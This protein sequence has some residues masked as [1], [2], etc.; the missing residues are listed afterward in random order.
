LYGHV[1][2]DEVGTHLSWLLNF[3]G[4]KCS[5]G[6]KE[7]KGLTD[8]LVEVRQAVHLLVA[9]DL[10]NLKFRKAENIKVKMST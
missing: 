2:R 10:I 9:W 8:N 1:R 5:H 6:R 7:P 3:A 4:N